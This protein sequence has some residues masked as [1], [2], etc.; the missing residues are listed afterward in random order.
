MR[1][2]EE[3]EQIR[4]RRVFLKDFSYFRGE[5]E[6]REGEEEEEGRWCGVVGVRIEVS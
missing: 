2:K 1:R 5:R 3:K 4:R 6:K